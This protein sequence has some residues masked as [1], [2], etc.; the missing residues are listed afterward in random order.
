[1]TGSDFYFRRIPG[2]YVGKRF[3]VSKDREEGG[4]LVELSR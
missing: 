4:Q 2:C 1:M 3:K